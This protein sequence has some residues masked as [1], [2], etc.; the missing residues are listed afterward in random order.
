VNAGRLAYDP[1]RLPWLPN[2]QRPPWSTSRA[3]ANRLG[4]GFPWALAVPW[5]LLGLL[6]LAAFSYWLGMRS[7]RDDTAPGQFVEAPASEARIAPSITPEPIAVPPVAVAPAIGRIEAVPTPVAPVRAE[8]PV[9]PRAAP[10]V[11]RAK[12]KPASKEAARPTEPGSA[13]SEP[14]PRTLEAWPAA[15]SR[16][17][18]GRMVRIGTF[19]SAREAKRAWWQLMRAYPGMQ[20][21]KAVV[22]PV[23]S[24]R[25][26]QT[27]YRLQFGTTSQA[28]SAVLCQRMLMIGQPCVVVG[29]GSG[30]GATG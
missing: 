25:N 29:L 20:R 14:R 27:Y 22:V 7:T 4:N 24:L 6:L 10:P 28:H 3:G 17:A 2:E 1:D 19:H 15:I 23:E 9:R 5:A 13:E 26:R 18:A 12:A 16:G 11:A 30:G 8:R 21:L